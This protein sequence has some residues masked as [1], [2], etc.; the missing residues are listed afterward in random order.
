MRSVI[1]TSRNYRP[2]GNAAN[3]A[4]TVPARHQQRLPRP[5]GAVGS[6]AV[7]AKQLVSIDDE[8]GDS[9]T[10]TLDQ[11]SAGEDDSKMTEG[12]AAASRPRHT[13]GDHAVHAGTG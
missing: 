12:A 8:K 1:E 3:A 9:G 10:G 13:A 4:A 5:A 6:L 2:P 11:S 7:Q